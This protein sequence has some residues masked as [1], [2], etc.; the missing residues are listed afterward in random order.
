MLGEVAGQGAIQ[1]LQD[2]RPR[3]RGSHGTRRPGGESPAW[4]VLA[5][6]LRRELQPPGAK[7]R[8]ARYLGLPR[9]R[10]HEYL[11]SRARLPDAEVTLQLL[12][13]LAAKRAGRDLS[14]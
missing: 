8:L 10:I 2:L 4:N 1:A 14:L 7:V 3:R 11:G 12:H 9:Q 5:A 13:W 6:A